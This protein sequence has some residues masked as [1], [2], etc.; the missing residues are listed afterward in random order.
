LAEEGIQPP[1]RIGE[2]GIAKY[3]ERGLPVPDRLLK[4]EWTPAGVCE[5]LHRDDYRGI[6]WRGQRVNK[7]GRLGKRTKVYTDSSTWTKVVDEDRH[8]V[9][10]LWNRAHAQLAENTAKNLR[11]GKLIVGKPETFKGRRLLSTLVVCAVCGRA[12][13]AV[14]RGRKQVLSY[15]CA[16]RRNNGACTNTT[17]VPAR[18]PHREVVN[19]LRGSFNPLSFECHLMEAAN[20]TEA[21]AVRERERAHITNTVLPEVQTEGPD[22]APMYNYPRLLGS[23]RSR[24]PSPTR[25][26]PSTVR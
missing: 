7:K 13:V 26:K 12:M 15:V 17:G 14:Q 21:A 11:M 3:Q 16:T 18:E 5:I 4:H 2:R 9:S 23:S 22:R 19:A 25:L 10:D 8:I 6:V 24:R 20:N 1:P